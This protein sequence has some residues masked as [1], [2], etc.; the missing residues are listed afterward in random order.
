[1]EEFNEQYISINKFK[2]SCIIY[3]FFLPIIY[4]IF[5]SL[6][7]YNFRKDYNKNQLIKYYNN[8]NKYPIYNIYTYK[9]NQ[10]KECNEYINNNYKAIYNFCDC[11]KSTKS[12][13]INKIYN[14]TCYTKEYIVGC[15]DIINNKEKDISYWRGKKLCIERMNLENSYIYIQNNENCGNDIDCGYIDTN[16]TNKLCIKNGKCPI[17]NVK[18]YKNNSY[19]NNNENNENIINLDNDYILEFNNNDNN[20]YILV[21]FQISQDE[22]VCS[23]YLEGNLGEVNKSISNI[24]GPNIC[25]NNGYYKNKNNY[26]NNSFI[27]IDTYSYENFSK[28]NNINDIIEYSPYLKSIYNNTKLTLHYNPYFG[29]IKNEKCNKIYSYKYEFIIM[30]NPKS[31]LI[32]AFFIIGIIIS[33]LKIITFIIII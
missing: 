10:T 6:F 20:N 25:L 23:N 28:D 31:K 21:N 18:I 8:W 16:K 19:N 5:L 7:I 24:N 14:R 17:N 33:C 2:T 27:K 11:T 29:L 12:N 1:M 22:Y 3:F 15:K 13:L 30:E 9:E 4:I 32:F 26:D